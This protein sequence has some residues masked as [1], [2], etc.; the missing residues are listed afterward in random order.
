MDVLGY[1][2]GLNNDPSNPTFNLSCGV[3]QFFSFRILKKI[4]F[5]KIPTR[6]EKI[7]CMNKSSHKYPHVPINPVVGE[8]KALAEYSATNEHHKEEPRLVVSP[9]SEGALW[10][11]LQAHVLSLQI[12]VTCV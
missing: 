2:T 12:C 11:F 9:G 8:K 7:L 1:I 5:S 4:C 10:R 3:L 6:R